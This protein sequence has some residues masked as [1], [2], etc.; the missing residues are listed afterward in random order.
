MK[1][2]K[3]AIAAI[4]LFSGAQTV[5]ASETEEPTFALVIHGGA[6]TILKKNMTPEKEAAYR[7]KLKE[8]LLVGQKILK[9]GGSALDAVVASIQV[10]E[11][12]PLFNA[13]KG[14]VFTHEG[15]NEMDAS[16]MN[17]ADLN[18]GAVASVMRVKNPIALAREVMENSDHVMLS[19]A[20]AEEF[21]GT[22]GIDLMDP[23]YFATDRRRMQLEKA[24]ADEKGTVLDHDGDNDTSEYDDPIDPERKFGTVGV[25]ALDQ[26]GN[27]AAGTSTG[28]MTNKRWK[29]VGDTPIIGAG[30]YADNNSCGV[31]ATGHGEYFIRAAVAYSI[32][33]RMEFQGVS[34]NEAADAVIMQKLVK[35]GGDGGIVALDKDG[36][37]SMTFNTEGMYRGYAKG[38]ATPV[39]AIYGAEDQ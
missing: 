5:S 2:I 35:M 10:M 3:T 11:D 27:I 8:S 32:C 17:G 7:A 28:G 22:R 30:T 21:A 9:D 33:A 26:T 19:G 37:I 31:S 4:A 12:S 20:G 1:I 13:G 38:N 29:R 34:L 15:G 6:G 25:V 23:S 39:T 16:I 36:N 24:I 18:A 14:A